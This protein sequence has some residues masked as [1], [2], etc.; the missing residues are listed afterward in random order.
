MAAKLEQEGALYDLQRLQE[1]ADRRNA[2]NEGAK[3]DNVELVDLQSKVE[4][5]REKRDQLRERLKNG[6]HEIVQEYLKIGQSSKKDYTDTS[7]QTVLTAVRL[8]HKRKLADLC[9]A[10]RLTGISVV[11]QEAKRTCFRCETFFNSRY[12]E[13]YYVEV[14]LKDTTLKIHKHTV[15]YFIPIDTISQQYLN[16][17]IKKFFM[18]ISEHLNAFVARREQVHLCQEQHGD[19]LEGEISCSPAHDFV[20]LKSKEVEGQDKSVVVKLTYDR[21]TLTRPSHVD[22]L[23]EGLS[24]STFRRGLQAKKK[25]F[26][27]LY[28]YQAFAEAFTPDL[29]A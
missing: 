20:Q 5:L 6:P 27:D 29:I 4:Q 1:R 25:L 15:P 22:L 18:V 26:K 2:E 16:S 23:T 7:K 10:Y 3:Q 8:L 13:P 19:K 17:D 12:H 14:E 11:S 28:L 24:T 21:L 9:D